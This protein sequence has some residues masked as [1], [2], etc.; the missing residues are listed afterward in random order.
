LRSR[1][2]TSKGN[3]VD[4]VVANEPDKSPDDVEAKENPVNLDFDAAFRS[5]SWKSYLQIT[6]AQRR[7]LDAFAIQW[8]TEQPVG[9]ILHIGT[10]ELI[11][12]SCR[13]GIPAVHAL[14]YI[15]RRNYIFTEDV[16]EVTKLKQPRYRCHICCTILSQKL[17]IQDHYKEV[18]DS[19][20]PLDIAVYTTSEFR[21]TRKGVMNMTR[22]RPEPKGIY[23]RFRKRPRLE[24]LSLARS[25]GTVVEHARVNSRAAKC[26]QSKG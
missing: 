21:L 20:L 9:S 19:P 4:E 23:K 26:D 15:D 18:H 6:S 5:S 14:D 1:Y 8:K 25:A 10:P 24:M 2:K 12:I 16:V 17:S 7:E 11:D 13:I 3:L 22:A